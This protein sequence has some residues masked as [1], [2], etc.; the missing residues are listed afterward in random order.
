[1]ITY[2]SKRRK[3]LSTKTVIIEYVTI[4]PAILANKIEKAFTC[5]CSWRDIDEDHYE[6]TVIG[7]CAC[8]MNEL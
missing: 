7:I 3:V 2:S 4:S 1:M 5:L 8:D 6:L